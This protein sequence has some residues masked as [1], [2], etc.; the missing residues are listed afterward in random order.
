MMTAIENVQLPYDPIVEEVRARGQ[1]LTQRF[2]NDPQKQRKT[3]HPA[4]SGRRC[5]LSG[6]RSSLRRRLPPSATR[7]TIFNLVRNGIQFTAT[8]H[9]QIANPRAGL[10]HVPSSQF[11]QK[12]TSREFN[13]SLATQAGR[14]H[15]SNFAANRLGHHSR[16]FNCDLNHSHAPDRL[17]RASPASADRLCEAINFNR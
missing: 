17:Q 12:S 11:V 7:K 14:A 16:R 4:S 15:G 6:W 5:P 13:G 8:P 2:D 10:I 3:F 1:Q 9:L